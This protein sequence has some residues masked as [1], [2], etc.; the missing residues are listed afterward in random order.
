MSIW[1][2]IGKIVGG[3]LF[4]LFLALAIFMGS[5]TDFTKNDNLKP[6]A[7]ELIKSQYSS[8]ITEEQLNQT[9]A[10]LLEGCRMVESI[11]LPLGAQNISLSCKDVRESTPQTLIT[12]I[13]G[14]TFDAFYYKK[15]SCSFIECLKQPGQEKLLVLFSL[16]AH[17][18][19]RN[20]QIYLWGFTA[21]SLIILLV[22]IDT[23][24]KRLK[25]L[26]W[27]LIFVGL[28][29]VLFKYLKNLLLP[30]IPANLENLVN[31]IINK[32]VDSLSKSFLIVLIVGIVL[33]MCGYL[34]EFYL[35]KKIKK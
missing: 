9:H 34:L 33:L 29:V 32:L 22:S 16:K 3:F 15:Y 13:G 35:K 28:P 10:M 14:N 12:L 18:I 7:T 2:S 23:W 20:I 4:T 25:N 6:I 11:E 30:P 8:F 26:G 19:F 31:P 5:I 21:V 24:Q 1:K 17:E 27:S